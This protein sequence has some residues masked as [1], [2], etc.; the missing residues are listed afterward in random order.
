MAVRRVPLKPELIPLL[1]EFQKDLEEVFF[2]AVDAADSSAEW[3][4]AR[5][6][7][8]DRTTQFWKALE[9]HYPFVKNKGCGLVEESGKYF[10]VILTEKKP[11]RIEEV[12]GLPISHVVQ[13]IF[14]I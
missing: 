12:P 3:K 11:T 1:V 4:K 6:A 10:I 2:P 9:P 14:K 8:L 7:T 13:R 5:M